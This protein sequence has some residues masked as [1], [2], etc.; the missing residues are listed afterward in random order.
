M[1]HPAPHR[2][3]VLEDFVGEPKL[4]E[5]MNAARRKGE[6]DRAQAPTASEIDNAAPAGRS[7]HLREATTD[8]KKLSHDQE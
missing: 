8:K 7:R 6:I 2:D 5:R 3:C 1:N 4:F